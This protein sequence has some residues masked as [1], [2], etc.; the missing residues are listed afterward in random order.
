[1]VE[2]VAVRS[3]PAQRPSACVI[4]L[5]V[6]ML[7]MAGCTSQPPLRSLDD[8]S[9][10]VCT[11]ADDSG[12]AVFAISTLERVADE[13]VQLMDAT[14]REPEGVELAGLELRAVDLVTGHGTFVGLPDGERPPAP[15]MP[16]A[17]IE[18]DSHRVVV[19][20][21]RLTGEQRGGTAGVRLQVAEA[22][23]GDPVPVD[24]R[25]RLEVVAPGATCG[26]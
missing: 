25:T 14:L 19:V 6:L 18:G 15:F 16:P 9:T 26:G 4:S 21:L 12:L 8:P 5:V 7:A 13:P 17:A 1:M 10:T 23:G 24:T 2:R 3:A 11:P 22:S 20:A